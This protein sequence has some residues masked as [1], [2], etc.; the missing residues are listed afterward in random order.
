MRLLLA[1]V[2]LAAPASLWAASGT[3]GPS[4]RTGSTQGGLNLNFDRQSG[5]SRV[6][7]GFQADYRSFQSSGAHV[8]PGV[9]G[10]TT[11]YRPSGFGLPGVYSGTSRSSGV[12]LP[13]NFS[14]TNR[15]L[16]PGL[17][18]SHFGA[19][20]SPGYVASWGRSGYYYPFGTGYA[21]GGWIPYSPFLLGGFYGGSNGVGPFE[22]VDGVMFTNPPAAPV[23]GVQAPVQSTLPAPEAGG[24]P[25]GGAPAGDQ[26]RAAR[27]LVEAGDTY[28]GRGEFARAVDAYR[29]AARNA[30][31]DPM[32][33][34][35][36]G[37]GLFAIGAYAQAA[38]ELRRAL[39]LYPAMVQVAMNR[40]A[41]YG[42][43]VRFDEQVGR[44]ALYVETNPND[45]AARFLLG[46]NCFFSGRRAQAKDQFAALGP[47]DAIAQLFL[48]EL[49]RGQ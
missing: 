38:A 14:C 33:A 18:G 13:G 35:A 1:V 20:R 23:F 32:A 16:G 7:G 19:R 9:G 41:F 45:A 44:L 8:L 21:Y 39:G 31:D 40:R 10:G 22:F 24:A 37:H 15:S 28:F 48:E 12:G 30:P 3:V 42:D 11:V 29:T 34:F 4:D 17:P 49:G 36:L 43:P 27:R 26:G 47:Q 2:V 46:Y 6:T 25:V 5:N